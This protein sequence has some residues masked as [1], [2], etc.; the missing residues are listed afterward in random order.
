MYKKNLI[1]TVTLAM[2][3]ATAGCGKE[4][5]VSTLENATEVVASVEDKV[6]TETPKENTGKV[7]TPSVTEPKNVEAP[8][9]KKIENTGRQ[10][11]APAKSVD[12]MTEAEVWSYLDSTPPEKWDVDVVCEAIILDADFEWASNIP[13]AF[14]N[15]ITANS[16]EDKKLVSAIEENTQNFLNNYHDPEGE[17]MYE[18]MMAEQNGGGNEHPTGP[19]NPGYTMGEPV[20]HTIDRGLTG[21]IS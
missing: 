14:W 18:Q 4:E 6:A 9:Q 3:I 12:S 1:T 17:A 19:R 10:V 8:D 15:T 13:D 2:I 21:N 16:E 7:T 5:V 20:E 11:D